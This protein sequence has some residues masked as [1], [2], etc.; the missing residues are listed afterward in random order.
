MWE[1]QAALPAARAPLGLGARVQ[2]W[3]VVVRHGTL[4]LGRGE[5]VGQDIVIAGRAPGAPLPVTN[6]S[7]CVLGGQ[8]TSPDCI[9]RGIHVVPPLCHELA[10]CEHILLLTG[11]PALM[12]EGDQD[13]EDM[14]VCEQRLQ[15]ALVSAAGA[16]SVSTCEHRQDDMLQDDTELMDSCPAVKIISETQAW[17]VFSDTA[18]VKSLRMSQR[19][20][21][22]QLSPLTGDLAE[23]ILKSAGVAPVVERSKTSH[24]VASRMI[25]NAL[26]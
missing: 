22:L 3:W 20:Q 5:R 25:A 8:R 4:A 23:S 17:V 16:L 13:E 2:A 21:K 14:A 10:S 12:V 18:Q 26:R 7:F 19:T 6:F 1:I 11:W 9:I 15:R 24:V